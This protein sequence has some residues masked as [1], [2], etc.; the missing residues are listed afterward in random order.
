MANRLGEVDEVVPP[1]AFLCG[2]DA[3]WMTAQTIRVNGGMA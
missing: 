2:P 1:V 3:R